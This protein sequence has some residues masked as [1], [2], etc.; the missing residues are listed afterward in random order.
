MDSNHWPL[1]RQ[2]SKIV[3]H[4]FPKFTQSGRN[5]EIRT[6]AV[7]STFQ[8]ITPG[9]CTVDAAN[10]AEARSALAVLPH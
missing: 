6:M 7:F 10:K 9:C 1:P 5:R 2:S 4:A 3:F 8:V